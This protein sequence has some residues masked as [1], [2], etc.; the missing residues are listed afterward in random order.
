[1]NYKMVLI[2]DLVIHKASTC[3]RG[4]P[5]VVTDL[6]YLCDTA[7]GYGSMSFPHGD[8]GRLLASKASEAPGVVLTRHV[9]S[10]KKDEHCFVVVTPIMSD[11]YVFLKSI[12]SS[13]D[14]LTIDSLRETLT[15]LKGYF[16]N[17]LRNGIESNP[18]RYSFV[19]ADS[20]TPDC[21]KYLKQ[22][23]LPSFD[24]ILNNKQSKSCGI[25]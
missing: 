11:L 13:S 9:P 12:K 21:A 25:L 1:M 19:V 24:L 6:R 2:S 3:K 18:S 20:K 16:P 17:R 14:E 10:V 5:E 22:L 23:M 4:W 8:L 7:A 15:L